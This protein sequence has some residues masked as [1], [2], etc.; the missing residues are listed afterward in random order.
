[1][2]NLFTP[3][4]FEFFARYLLA[5]FILI[6]VR[7]RFVVGERPKPTEIIFEAIVLSLINQ[8]FFILAGPSLT[9]LASLVDWTL[10]EQILLLAEVLFLPAILGVL[11]GWNLSQGWNHALLRRLSMPID[12]SPKFPPPCGESLV[13]V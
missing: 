7:S 8:L 4:T 11:A 5:G 1:M 12:L 10:S 2:P 3:E 6:S 9:S 13:W